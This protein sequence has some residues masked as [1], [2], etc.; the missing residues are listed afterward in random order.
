MSRGSASS[1]L[2]QLRSSTAQRHANWHEL[3]EEETTAAVAELAEILAGRDDEPV[4]LAEVAGLLE[5][6]H[7]CELDEAKARA[8][9]QLCC[10]A[11]ADEALIPQWKRKAPNGLRRCGSAL[12]T[13]ISPPSMTCS[14]ITPG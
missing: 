14:C 9:V 5:G 12:C 8:A 11:G 10:L 7:Q 3:T 4:L 2:N 1:S 6:F 13:C